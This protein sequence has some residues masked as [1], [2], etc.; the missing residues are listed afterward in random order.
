MDRRTFLAASAAVAASGISARTAF[1]AHAA[2]PPGAVNRVAV[3]GAGIVGASIAYNLSKRGCDVVLIEKH[4]P[5]AQASGNSFAWI[6]ASYFDMP[7]SYFTLRTHS[8]NE[9]HRLAQDVDIPVRWGGSLEWYHSAETTREIAESVQRIQSYG[10]PA[11]MIDREKAHEI[12]PKLNL[13]SSELAVW[14]SRDGAVDPAGVTRALI[15]RVVE[16]GGTTVYPATV[17]GVR[18][19]SDGVVVRTDIDSFMVDL[20]IVAA[21][22]GANQLASMADLGTNLVQPATPGVIVTTTPMAPLLNTVCYTTDTHF[23]QL[24]DGRVVLGEKAGPPQTDQ[25]RAMLANQPNE[26]PDPQLSMEHARRVIDLARKYVPELKDAEVESVGVGWRPLPLDG[27]PV[28]GRPENNPGIYLAA[29]H[30]GVTLA[31]IVGRLA[32]MEILDGVSVDL[33]SDFRVE[34]FL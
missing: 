1:A 4:E 8:L 32:A 12:E 33:L 7:K 17:T 23:H 31:P 16:H 19:N 5:A 3:I 27:L 30:S 26:Y 22:T 20:A 28:I 18:E 2:R 24:A 15:D 29:M 25:H 6:N 11:W 9:Y 13:A 21:G 34:R 10:A 14:S